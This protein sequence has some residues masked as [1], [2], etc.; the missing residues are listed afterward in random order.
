[1]NFK[2][3]FTVTI[4]LTSLSSFASTECGKEGSIE[5]RISDCGNIKK[6]HFV[7]VARVKVRKD[8]FETYKDMRTKLLWSDSLYPNN[9]TY[10]NAMNACEYY[11]RENMSNIDVNWELPT[12]N[13]WREAERSGMRKALPNMEDFFWTS[14]ER[15][16]DPRTTYVLNGVYGT[17]G[18]ESS[19]KVRCVGQ[20]Y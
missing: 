7:L 17:F 14:T 11:F 2:S 15:R 20:T 8:F 13:M 12:K 18:T 3:L 4:L 10:L 1:M 5:E 9:L 16:E 6:E 19:A